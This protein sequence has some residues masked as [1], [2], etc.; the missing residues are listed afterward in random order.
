MRKKGEIHIM[1][2]SLNGKELGK[3][4]TQRPNHAYMARFVDSQG[5]R[6]TLYDRNLKRLML[7][8]EKARY[9]SE[10]G[11]YGTGEDVS[12]ESWFESYLKLYKEGRVKITTLY[13]NRQTFSS[14]KKDSL[15]RMKLQEIRAFHIQELINELHD[16][17]YTYGTLKLLK[18]L[19]SEMFKMAIGNGLMLRNPCDAVILPLPETCEQE[20]L[21]EK[22]IEMF[23]EAAAEY[24]HLEIFCVDLSTGMRIGEVL[25]L[26]WS[27]IDF[28][29]KTI[30]IQRTLHYGRTSDEESCHFFF[31]T[32]K[33][34]KSERVIPLFPETEEVLKKVKEKQLLER[35][36]HSKEWKEK[37]PF[38]DLVFTTSKGAPVRYGDVNRTIKKAVVKANLK[39][40]ELAKIENREPHFLKEFSPHCFRH[41]FVTL[42]KMKGIPYEYIQLYVGHSNKEMTKYYDHNKV[43]LTTEDFKNVTFLNYGVKMV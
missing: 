41:T 15:G 10:Q 18:N 26:K 32:P 12:L 36:L 19:L 1:G 34:K 14:C 22:E 5:K 2:K 29:R 27:D 35:G 42:C 9:E 20:V 31:T 37:A 13:R 30:T 6:R 11:M 33:T 40:Q 4:I 24:R 23:L 8:L 7:K 17:G 25:G 16:K 43:E 38:D 39:E 28:E 3:G 21:S